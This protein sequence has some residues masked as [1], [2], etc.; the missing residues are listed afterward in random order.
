MPSAPHILR[1]PGAIGI[2]EAQRPELVE[3]G[4]ANL[5]Q[6]NIRQFRNGEAA[7]RYGFGSFSNARWVDGTTPSAGY[8]L[9]ADRNS[10]VRIVDG[11]AE[12]YSVKTPGWT[13]LGRVSE[14]MARLIDL[15]SMG[16]ATNLQDVDATN[17][18]VAAAWLSTVVGTG[19]CSAY[20]SLVDQATGSM[21]RAPEIVGTSTANVAGMLA[22]QG[23]YFVFVRYNGT[24]TKLEA[25]YLDTTSASTITT[26]WVAF[27]ASLCT[28]ATSA[29]FALHT[30]PHASTPRVAV[31]Y[32]NSSGG[33][34][35]ITVKT[36]NVG[37]V[38]QTQTINTGG[39]TPFALGLGGN[40]TDTLWLV[41]GEGANVRARGLSPFTITTDLA[42][43]ATVGVMATSVQLICVAP[44]TTAGAA[45]WWA[46]D[47]D[48]NTRSQMRGIKT[49]AG[50]AVTNGAQMTIAGVK[51]I[52]KPFVV[53]GRF[54]S[55]FFNCN[56]GG[57]SS[58]DNPQ[59]IFVVCD[60][61]DDINTIRPVAS[62][63]P[64]IA[65]VSRVLTSLQ[66][67]GKFV[68]GTT[69]TTFVVGLAIKRSAIADGSALLELDFA[70]GKR[71]QTCAHG[72]GATGMAGGVPQSFDGVRAAEIG[73]LYRPPPPQITTAGTGI[74]AA[75][76]WKYVVVYE[77]TDSEGNWH[78]SG[79]SDPSAS[80]GV[81]ANK[82]VT[83]TSIPLAITSRLTS[84]G[85][86]ARGVRAAWYRTLDGGQPPY[87]R[88]GT[89]INDPT[90]VTVAYADTTSDAVLATASQLYSQPGVIGTSQDRRSPPFFSSVVSYSGM[91]VGASG[92]DVWNSGQ[93]VAGEATWFNPIF[94][95]P[96]PGVGDI[97]A[98][99]VLDGTLFVFKRN[100]V[101]VIAGDA[102]SDNGAAGG[103]G[104]PRRLATDV[105][106]IDSRS[107]C[108]TALGIFFQSARGIEVLTRAQ[109]VQWIGQGVQNTLAAYPVV[110]SATVVPSLSG[111]TVVIELA[112]S[113]S[114]GVVT[115]N[116]HSIV[117]DLAT[118]SW[119]STDI[120]ASADGVAAAPSQSAC[121]IYTGSAYRYAWM[122]SIGRVHYEDPTTYLDANGSFVVPLIE[123]AYY[124]AYQ[125]EQRVRSASVL[126]QQYSA[127]GLKVESAY[128]YGD[129]DS[130]DDAA[131]SEVDTLNE[132]QLELEN[133]PR[134]ETIKFRITATA[135]AV[136]GTGQGFGFIGIALDVAS[137]QGPTKGTLR[138]DPEKRR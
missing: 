48:A 32:V 24:G 126:F 92:S 111:A 130:L 79:L 133:E 63:A 78:V 102:P 49:T 51:M 45:R 96:I 56:T 44:S 81:V 114:G 21:V 123:T 118:N 98:L 95:V 82:T 129:Y 91:L 112:A 97:T 34:S 3:F 131:W 57:G 110:T 90:A 94:Q 66:P 127:A 20:L 138:L 36:F 46:N 107:T 61:T 15:P 86:G 65:P 27:G 28:D 42:T 60:W 30:L 74:S 72:G 16:T 121:V 69:A 67:C 7:T 70:S 33:A 93:N 119:V 106:C 73:F 29:A 19:S 120:R 135:P 58:S 113:E 122:S 17:G 68:A 136:L 85:S 5:R 71:W 100:D 26:G 87:Y 40:A 109:T 37:G 105:G 76:G 115:G 23:N 134:G 99:A 9:F 52:R 125:Q 53:G 31:A 132:R 4:S 11:Q 35:Q 22:V 128:D 55:A 10:V 89:T 1:S 101:Y 12:S 83:A 50:A 75:S 62:A 117:F 84:S 14:V 80:T 104:T 64:G 103:L 38:V 59:S 108:T 43:V 13:V 77:E 124:N 18:Y 39:V 137:K 2:N 6:E 47:N 8:K 41:W 116:G 88:L 54:Y 25:F